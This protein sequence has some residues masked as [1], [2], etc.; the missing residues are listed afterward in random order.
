MLSSQKAGQLLQQYTMYCLIEQTALQSAQ[1]SA[2]ASKNCPSP[3][4]GSSD[5]LL[6]YTQASVA[7]AQ[8]KKADDTIGG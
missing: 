8:W 7:T 4:A 1:L 2:T 5:I 6:L 3:Q